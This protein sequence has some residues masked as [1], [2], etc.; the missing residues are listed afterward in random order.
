MAEYPIALR[1]VLSLYG[2]RSVKRFVFRLFPLFLDTYNEPQMSSVLAAFKSCRGFDSLQQVL[3][4]S[5][6][7]RLQHPSSP[8]RRSGLI[9]ILSTLVQRWQRLHVLLR[10]DKSFNEPRGRLQLIPG[11]L[12]RWHAK[13]LILYIVL[14]LGE[15][16]RQQDSQAPRELVL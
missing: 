12:P 4:L 2:G 6:P 11:M 16:A 14:V 3:L 9:Q 15:N 13:H 8:F 10:Q 7:S 1:L 5:L